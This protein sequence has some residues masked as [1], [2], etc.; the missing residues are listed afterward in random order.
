MRDNQPVTQREYPFPAGKSLVSTTD[1]KGRILH[2]NAAFI[3]VSGYAR[4][5]LLGQP[6]NLIRHPDM[7]EEAFRDLWDTIAAG[8]PWSGLV[9]NR[10]KDG[11]HYWVVANVTPLLDA[12]RPVAY[13]SVR[14]EPT[15]EQIQAAEALYARM[16]DEARSGRLQHRLNEGQVLRNGWLHAAQRQLSAMLRQADSWLGFLLMGLIGW[17]LSTLPWYGALPVLLLLAM[18]GGAWLRARRRAALAPLLHFANQL[19]AGDLSGKLRPSGNSLSRGL[20]MALSQLCVN[21]RALV[22]DS[23]RELSRMLVASSAIAK[24]SSD[25]SARTES[26]A[27]SLEE[28]AA[29]MEQITAT[30]RTSADATRRAHNVAEELNAVSRR[31][32]DVVHSVTDTMSAIASSSHR[33]GEIIQLIE[34]I[35]FQTNILALNAAVEA[36]RA[37]EHGRGFA[38]VASEVRALAGRSSTAAKEIRQLI[39]DSAQK[40]DAG[41]IQ[42]RDARQSIDETLESVRQFAGI[43]DGIDTGAREQLQGISQ[44]HEAIQQLDGITQNNA[45][46]VEELASSA[47][48]L[49]AQ[50]TEVQA[51]LGVFRLGGAAQQPLPDAVALR[52]EAK[53][54]MAASRQAA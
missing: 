20:E 16:R 39:S 5:E 12:G 48:R 38:V 1:L 21:M 46:L 13:M 45:S 47:S 53:A 51:A 25:L 8:K 24:G 10:R 28:T 23:Q 9:K 3:E 41:E 19:A 44:I 22:A 29:S 32:G 31:S 37:G 33:I 34:G 6:H 54:Q 2:C 26:Q 30:V 50:A 49:Q 15:R 4:D 14:S 17:G 27:A 43:I 7:P 11:D 35:A 40:V 42:T 36:A 52:R 18:A